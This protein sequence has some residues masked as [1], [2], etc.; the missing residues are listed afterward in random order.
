MIKPWMFKRGLE[1]ETEVY[2]AAHP[3]MTPAEVAALDAEIKGI[4]S[5]TPLTISSLTL[6][7][8]L[9]SGAYFIHNVKAA[10]VAFD[11]NRYSGISGVQY[12]VAA[13]GTPATTAVFSGAITA[14]TSETYTDILA[15]WDFTSGWTPEVVTTIIDSNSY[16]TTG[17]G[18][19]YTSTNKTILGA[20]YKAT[21]GSDYSGDK[22]HFSNTA[23]V[24]TGSPLNLTSAVGTTYV[25]SNATQLRVC[26]RH[27][28]EATGNISNMK[29]EK[30][31]TP[32]TTGILAAALTDGGI[33]ANAVTKVVTVSR[34]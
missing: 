1:F 9:V 11:L 34:P 2:F 26:I 7:M 19:L 29:L 27:V 15:G 12:S 24:T 6:Y 18:G 30:V 23:G 31:L 16:S 20:L 10:G 17:T 28:G 25:T 33:D 14:G 5:G 32:D 8:S 22:M 21:F 4:K 13:T 3:T